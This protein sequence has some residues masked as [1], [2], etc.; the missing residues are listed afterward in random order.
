MKTHQHRL[1]WH[2]GV[3]LLTAVQSPR[4]VGAQTTDEVRGDSLFSHFQNAE[5]LEAYGRAVEEGGTFS[6]F[7]KRAMAA[8]EL[9]QDFQADGK[10][11]EAKRMYR[12]AVE[13]ARSARD[14]YPE[15]A[16]SWF[17]LAAT[18]GKLAQFSGGKSKVKI[19]RAV[20]E[21]YR[22]AISLDST[23]ALAYL[24]GGIFQREVA[25]LSWFQRLAAK[26]L[27]GGVPR[28][29]LDESRRLL[30]RSLELE[31][32]LLM[33]HW[34]LAQTYRAMK[35]PELAEPH[36]RFVKVL[37]PRSSEERRIRKKV[38]TLLP[39]EDAHTEER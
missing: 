22:K 29:S 6:A 36:L 24:A 11:D 34:E 35:K 30:Q 21:Y 28:G 32:T 8:N 4:F 19:G 14:A 39:A 37:A 7:Y 1:A 12:G 20:E 2:L 17:M 5:A 23:F 13:Y 26:A 16:G 31:P 33:A 25:Q 38:L 18:N 10:K 27:F 9:A 3:L 15:E